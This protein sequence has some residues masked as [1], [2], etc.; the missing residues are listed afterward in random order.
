MTALWSDWR[1]AIALCVVSW[2]LWAFFGKICADRLGW[3]TASLLGWLS[4]TVVVALVAWRGFA[5]PGLAG[6]L[7]A[8]AYGV[9]GAVGA[10]FFVKAL[11][12]G[13]AVLVAPT[14]EL[15]LVLAV[16]LAV[17][18]LGEKMTLVR[19]AGLAL[20]LG[21]AALLSLKGT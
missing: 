9:F 18:F 20:M 10:V 5:W 7:P 3:P 11:E 21:G 17:L 8:F 12:S 4:G 1:L 15:Y 19:W 16:L 14:A 13:P 6:A 2:G